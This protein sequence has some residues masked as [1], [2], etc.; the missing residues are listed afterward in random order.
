MSS[1]GKSPVPSVE[2]S[3]EL[4]QEG[5]EERITQFYRDF[6][7]AILAVPER[8]Q[9]QK[10]SHQPTYPNDFVNI[11]GIQDEQRVIIPIFTRSELI[12]IW[13][14][15]ELLFKSYETDRF[16]TLIPEGWWVI[17]NPGSEY[18]K[19]FSPW[20]LD[21]LRGG[22]QSVPALVAE[23]IALDPIESVEFK[24]VPE[25]ELT[26]LRTKLKED[27]RLIPEVQK[28]FLIRENGRDLEGTLITTLIIGALIDPVPAND[29]KPIEERLRQ[30]ATYCQIGGESIKVR[31]GHVIEGNLLLGIFAGTPAFYERPTRGLKAWIT[32]RFRS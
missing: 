7:R 27:A 17:L 24:A 2:T 12:Q 30:T 5:N 31:V 32:N 21:Q 9:P 8:L 18:E 25:T 10:L 28:L 3:L 20:E 1:V 14:G 22:I 19:E 29:L 23:V 16:L 6:L 15:Q 4:A 11:L 13:C 26:D